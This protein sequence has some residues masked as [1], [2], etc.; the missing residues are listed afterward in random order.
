MKDLSTLAVVRRENACTLD[1]RILLDE[2]T[3]TLALYRGATVQSQ[4]YLGDLGSA[5]SAFVM[6]RTMDGLPIGCG[7]LCRFSFE[8]A[9]FQCLYRRPEWPGTGTAILRF[10]ETVAAGAGYRR[11][12]LQARE[13]NRR[14]ITFYQR[15]GYERAE[16]FADCAGLS[17]VRCFAKALPLVA[18][19]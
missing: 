5:R 3:A 8:V 6:A 18:D 17:D 1:A 15:H 10:L 9:E 19:E 4:F 11:V 16:P 13:A 2:M 7:A 12:I 14:A